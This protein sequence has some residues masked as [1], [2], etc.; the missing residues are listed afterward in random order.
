[1][2][3]IISV[4]AVMALMVAM[5]AASAMPA[6]AGGTCKSSYPDPVVDCRGGSGHGGGGEG[7]GGGGSGGKFVADYGDSRQL[8]EYSGGGGSRYGFRGGSHCTGGI[9]SIDTGADCVGRGY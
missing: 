8:V 3:R 7:N 6:F 1:M 4:L 9:G 5:L 2:K